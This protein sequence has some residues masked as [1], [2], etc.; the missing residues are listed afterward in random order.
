MFL[1]ADEWLWFSRLSCLHRDQ[2]GSQRVHSTRVPP[3][4]CLQRTYGSLLMEYL[5]L[6]PG[7]VD[8]LCFPPGAGS[9]PREKLC[10]PDL[11]YLY[12]YKYIT[13]VRGAAAPPGGA[14]AAM[15][16][17][18]ALQVPTIAGT[19]SAYRAAATAPLRAVRAAAKQIPWHPTAHM[20]PRC[21]DR[22][23]DESRCPGSRA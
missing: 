21:R 20:A 19:C 2:Q 22:G 3:M 10:L 7:V 9:G 8:Q 1:A 16:H 15:T 4:V 13:A 5:R 14:A 11:M 12:I 23:R 6:F 18:H 17:D